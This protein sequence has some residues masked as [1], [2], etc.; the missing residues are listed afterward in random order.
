MRAYANAISGIDFQGQ[1]NL[2]DGCTVL[3]NNTGLRVLD[4]SLVINSVARGNTSFGLFVGPNAGYRSC[5]LT[6]NNGG[7]ANAQVGG[8][9]FQL[10]SNVCGSDPVCP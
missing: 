8:T 6:G 2:V 7:D 5:V 3:N 4:G 1:G 10:G 9:G